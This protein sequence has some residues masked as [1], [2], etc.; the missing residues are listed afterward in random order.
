VDRSRGETG[1][2][3]APALPIVARAARHDWEEPCISGSRGSGAVFFSGCN[4]G[5][6]YCQNREISRSIRGK[7]LDVPALREL[8]ARLRDSG[9]HN[10]NLVT[11][12]P[13]ADVIAE[14]LETPPGIPVVWNCGG[15]ERVETL[16]MLEG[17][18][19]V[20]LPDMKYADDRLAKELSAA[21]DYF[22][23]ANAAI[24]E[25][26]RQT[27]PCRLDADGLLKRGV[28]VRHLV[29]PGF[30]AN[31]KD[32]LEWFAALPKGTALFSLMAQYTPNGFGGPERRLTPEEFSE[33]S[34][35]MYML[36]IRDGYVQELS[37][38]G[39]EYVP[40]FDGT[41]LR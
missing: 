23:T 4:L 39:S 5:C 33:V 37:S 36:G 11:A 26:V 28:V 3:G 34:D 19:D 7:P 18:I 12:T 20:Y 13:Y 17:K 22:E 32:V 16:R 2:C 35:Y 10:I 27:G 41:G 8:F 30:S 31:S 25:M 6:I 24:R 40:P 29:L 9:V 15:Y 21:G 38:A 14:A 1:F